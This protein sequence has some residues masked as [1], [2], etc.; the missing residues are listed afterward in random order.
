MNEWKLRAL[1]LRVATLTQN[2]Y[3][4]NFRGRDHVMYPEMP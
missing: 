2:D 3:P 1:I 4:N